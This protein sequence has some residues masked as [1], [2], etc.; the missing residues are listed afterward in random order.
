VA[1]PLVL[2]GRLA[3]ASGPRARNVRVAPSA[4]WGVDVRQGSSGSAA[5][6]VVPLP[7]D[8]SAAVAVAA[9]VVVADAVVVV[10]DAA[11][12]ADAVGGVRS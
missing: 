5:R 9:A 1:R 3:V 10:A 12:V 4:T 11:A 6:R 2:N 7:S 8:R